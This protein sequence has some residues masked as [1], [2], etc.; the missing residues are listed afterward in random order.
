MPKR[1]VTW[2]ALVLVSTLGFVSL[3][4]LAAIQERGRP[5]AASVAMAPTPERM[6]LP[7]ALDKAETDRRARLSPQAA[8]RDLDALQARM[9]VS[10]PWGKPGK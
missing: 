4:D 5:E 10:R 8:A 3:N 1:T 2:M 6:L 9:G 7:V